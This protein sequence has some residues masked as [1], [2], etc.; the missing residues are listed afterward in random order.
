[1]ADPR[2]PET[3]TARGHRRT[4]AIVQAIGF[5]GGIALLAWCVTL[6]LSPDNRAQLSKLTQA[7]ALQIVGLLGLSAAAIALNG[8]IF[9]IIL[10]PARRLPAADVIATNALATFLAYLPFKLSVAARFVIHSRRD[11][12]PVLTIG[13]WLAA[14]AAALVATLGPI[15][16]VSLWRRGVDGWWWAGSIAGVALGTTALLLTARA[17]AGETGLARLHRLADPLRI[18]PL[19]RA[20]RSHRF[21]HLHA[22]FAMLSSPWGVYGA[23]ALRLADVACLTAR[24]LI[25]AAVLGL[26]LPWPD[27]VLMG[28]TYFFVGVLS[29]FGM[30]GTREAGTLGLAAAVGVASARAGVGGE[31]SPLPVVILF[32]SGTESIINIAGAGFAVAWLRAGRLVGRGSGRAST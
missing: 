1:M 14:C 30:L 27:A 4:R 21:E 8:L 11:G 3:P 17:F 23:A 10:R 29:P 15:L 7:S 31:A 28:A 19:D 32:V 13:A 16:G 25:A 2:P 20:L 6:A 26:D 22:G 9:W 12:V 24:F 5:A 18:A